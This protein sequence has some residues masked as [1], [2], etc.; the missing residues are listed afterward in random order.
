MR[1]GQVLK[2]IKE[3]ETWISREREKYSVTKKNEENF[4]K[5]VF[6]EE[7]LIEDKIIAHS[8]ISFETTRCPNFQKKLIEFEET[9]GWRG[10]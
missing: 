6:R 8:E 9:R 5:Y 2:N 7:N 3:E 4:T 1:K 10:F